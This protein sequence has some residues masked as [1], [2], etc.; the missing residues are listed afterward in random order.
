MI[1]KHVSVQSTSL[2]LLCH[3]ADWTFLSTY[4]HDVA[5]G[6]RAIAKGCDDKGNRLVGEPE[7]F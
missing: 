5:T 4:P 1:D 7:F 3:E 6:S 2:A